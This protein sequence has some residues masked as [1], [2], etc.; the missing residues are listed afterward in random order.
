MY[1][2]PALGPPNCAVRFGI[3]GSLVEAARMREDLLGVFE[4]DP[5][6]RIVSQP[7]ALKL[8]EP[9]SHRL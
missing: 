7:L 1:Y 6:L 3:V 8:A 9:K 5:S 4:A 2:Q